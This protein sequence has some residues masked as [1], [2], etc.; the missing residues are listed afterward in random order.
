MNR[1][2]RP[3]VLDLSSTRNIRSRSSTSSFDY[4]QSTSGSAYSAGI[5]SSLL[6][7][8]PDPA[9]IAPA[10][11]TQIVTNNHGGFFDNETVISAGTPTIPVT[12][13]ALRLLNQFLDYLLY[14]FL[15][16][17]KS[18]SLP[19]LRTAVTA[20]LNKKV[21]RD[22][23]LGADEELHSYLGGTEGD[24]ADGNGQYKSESGD[25]DLERAWR[26]TR[27]R[28]MVYSSL[29]DLEEDDEAIY[30]PDYNLEGA[31]GS[32][33]YNLNSGVHGV[34]SPAVAIWLTAILEFIG[35][36]T[37]L[38]AGNATIARYSA[39][40]AAS[41]AVEE[42]F[43]R[44][45][46]PECPMVEELDTEKVA[47]NPS[48]GRIWRQWRKHLRGTGLSI[49]SPSDN[50]SYHW[51]SRP[52]TSRS[53]SGI[54]WTDAAGAI[55]LP[56][57]MPAYPEH[58]R[59]SPGL[60]GEATA[61]L[62]KS[63]PDLMEDKLGEGKMEED[64][65][66]N[67]PRTP[68]WETESNLDGPARSEVTE[69]DDDTTDI[70]SWGLAEY[71]D[72]RR[73]R[74][75]IL[76]PW[77][78]SQFDL[79]V[80]PMLIQRPRSLPPLDTPLEIVEIAE[81]I[82][83]EHV[84]VGSSTDLSLDVHQ[85]QDAQSKIDK[86]MDR[87]KLITLEQAELRKQLAANEDLHSRP[88][89]NI[90]GALERSLTVNTSIEDDT[91]FESDAPAEIEEVVRFVRA[92]NYVKAVSPKEIQCITLTPSAGRFK[93]R[94]KGKTGKS[95]LTESNGGG[96]VKTLNGPLT[97]VSEFQKLNGEPPI[98]DFREAID[99]AMGSSGDETSP[100][101]VG[102]SKIFRKIPSDGLS[103][104]PSSPRPPSSHSKNPS[105][106][107]ST[108]P[109][110]TEGRKN[111]YSSSIQNSPSTP[112]TFSDHSGRVRVRTSSG[113][114]DDL[115]PSSSMSR[116]IPRPIHSSSSIASQ[117][118]HGLRS[119]MTWPGNSGKRS[120]V[121]DAS[122]L[123]SERLLHRSKTR[124]EKERSFEELIQS[125]GTIVCTLTPDEIRGI[126]LPE[127]S[128]SYKAGDLEY[129]QGGETPRPASRAKSV[130]AKVP[131][132]LARDARVEEVTTSRDLALFLRS[133]GPPEGTV[134]SLRAT[135]SYSIMSNPSK[136]SKIAGSGSSTESS[137]SSGI[138]P[139]SPTLTV[140]S[141]MTLQR[142]DTGLS[143]IQSN[144]KRRFIAREARG[145]TGDSTSALADFFR[146]TLPPIERGDV[147]H[148]RISRSVAPFRT[149]M[150]SAQFDMASGATQKPIREPTTES[151]S[152]ATD[153][154]RSSMTS[155]T[156]L[157]N[158]AVKRNEDL[159]SAKLYIP[160][161]AP[162]RDGP[163]R[164]QRRVGDAYAIDDDDSDIESDID[165]VIT[166]PSKPARKEE[167]LADFLRNATPPPSNYPKLE[168][169]NINKKVPKKS[170]AVNLMAR[171]SRGPSRKSSISLPAFEK[172]QTHRPLQP[173]QRSD[174]FD[175]SRPPT[176]TPAQPTREGIGAKPMLQTAESFSR[177]V[178]LNPIHSLAGVNG[179]SQRPPKSQPKPVGEARGA[180][181]TQSSGMDE[182]AAFL[183][184]SAPLSMGPAP[185]R[186]VGSREKDKEESSGMNRFRSMTFR[187]KGKRKEVAGMV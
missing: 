39:L 79:P 128:P 8:S 2:S 110:C 50:T 63:L 25:W 58:L 5:L 146:N 172:P 148:H 131:A 186:R 122:S 55:A 137:P 87:I 84:L 174:A 147:V 176:V 149:T 65:D 187:S 26:R 134:G 7:A 105:S 43:G 142:I 136:A 98:S 145:S 139:A 34:V 74:S 130:A 135:A 112:S 178:D 132:N 184:D 173:I 67:N 154:Y 12:G 33:Q 88:E 62:G 171:L 156:G 47:L 93:R 165:L 103:S 32:Q 121:D 77:T 20:V 183:R 76:F 36:Q 161:R 21:A 163:V 97:P 42:K 80:D 57:P 70:E 29:G 162:M 66:T 143:T 59:A 16:T 177:P 181:I 140:P 159:V 101:P 151:G 48:L 133:T 94:V 56:L 19:I 155:S 18:T 169:V 64:I 123:R 99:T 68:L 96:S 120:D 116:I 182:L 152:T 45:P 53:L 51:S 144:N 85:P 13:P 23:I 4:G 40:R 83:P 31:V 71:D 117:I 9:F 11:A 168:E 17:A 95:S 166:A 129:V 30:A 109:N 15:A 81:L 22:T 102:K 24:E 92:S 37:L 86:L 35:E 61:S 127:P 78:V 44:S 113:G 107:I 73:P 46:V 153:S 124:D 72:G 114:A 10:A 150:D 75:M 27:V 175:G 160:K 106:S 52:S 141:V 100:T 119:F 90:T 60:G 38:I 185:E 82:V 108:R 3:H 104:A 126:E 14:S 28:C 158:S 180:R 49:C 6:E 170:S 91:D 41:S 1:E 179:T 157:L 111:S 138:Q 167:S 115:R 164:T 89:T 118:S 125:G 69:F 54:E